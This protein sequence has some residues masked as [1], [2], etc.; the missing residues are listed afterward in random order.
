[1]Q[2]RFFKIIKFSVTF[3]AFG[4]FVFSFN[5]Q[6]AQAAITYVAA[7]AWTVGTTSLVPPLPAGMVA[8]D[9]ML[10]VMHTANHAVTTP[11]GWTEVT[12]SPISAGTANAAG[13]VRI[14]VYYRWWVSGDATPTVSVTS[15]T[16]TNGMIFGYRGVDMTTPFD[17]TPTS[18]IVAAASTT[19]TMAGIT[20]VT[21]NAWIVHSVGRDQ[22]L[23]N[24]AAVASPVNTNLTGMTERHD[25]VV[26][27]GV[28]GGIY[29]QD[30][31][32]GSAG[33]T[34][35]TTATQT[36]SIA[37]NLTVALRPS[38]DVA[39]TVTTPTSASITTT[40]A[41]L[42][43]N[44]T[45]LGIPASISAR[46]VVYGTSPSP[47][48]NATVASGTTTGVYTIGVSSLTCNTLYYY[49]GYATNTTGAAYSSDDSFT[50]SACTTAP[51][52]TTQA[53][54]SITTTTAT[55]NG[56]VTSDGGSAITERGIA[57]NTATAP[58]KANFFATTTGTTGAYT[59]SLTS[60]TSGTLYYVRAYAI[61]SVGTTY[62]NE[63][64]FT[65]L[66][67]PTVTTPTVTSITS[68]GATLGANVTSLGIPD[69]ISAR[70]TCW[71]T[72]PAPV[73][74][75]TAEGLTTTGV[76]T[77]ARTGMATGTLYYYRGYA[78]NTTGTAYS[79]DGTFT[80][81]NVPTITTQAVSSITTTTATG[82]GDVT[83]DGGSAITERGIA[84]NTATAPTKA[85]FFATTTGT[86]GAYTSS[87]TSLTSGTL[88]YVRAYA[89]NSV[90]TTYGNEVTFTT[91]I[92]PTVTTPT[93]TSITSSG[94][95][96]GANVTSLGIPAAI[97]ARGV[98]Y[99]TSPSP[100]GNATVA[101][102]TTTGVYTIGVSSLTCNTLYY[103]RGYATNTTGTAYSSD[104]SFTT[105]ACSTTT[106]SNGTDPGNSTIGPDVAATD[107]DKF[108]LTTSVSTDNITALTVTLAPANSF[109]NLSKVEIIHDGTLADECTDIDNP[110]SV[111]LN[112]TGCSLAADIDGEI[113]RIRITPKTH[114]NMP[115]VPGA[116]YTITATVTAITATNATA[117]TDSGSATITV[118]NA[119]P[120]GVTSSTATA[121]NTVVNLAWTNP[122]DSDFTTGGTVVVLRRATS[123]VENVPAEGTTYTIG[124][125]IGTATVACVVTGSPPTTSCSDTGLT[126]DTA[127]H[128]K[129][130][131]QDSRGNYD[132]GIVP[133]GS[134]ATPNTTTTLGNG[135]NPANVTIA[136]SAPVTDLNNFSVQTNSGTD[137]ITGLTVT[138]AAGT[139]ASLSLVEITTTGNTDVCTDVANPG[140]DAVAFT[141]CTI[142]GTTS[143]T[144]YKVRITPKTHINMPVPPGLN[145]SVTGTVTSA[146]S[147]NVKIYNDSGSAT[148]TVDNLSPAN[149]SGESATPDDV[150][151]SL[152][153]TNPTDGDFSN[154]V[155]LRDT[156][157]IGSGSTPSESSSPTLDSSC[158]GTNCLVRYINSGTSFIDT[159]LTNNTTYYYKIFSKDMNGNYSV[160]TQL[161]AT[162][163]LDPTTIITTG[164]D[165]ASS[166]V[167]ESSTNVYLDQFNFKTN[168]D[169]DSITALVV[170]TTG[171]SNIVSIKIMSNDLA[172]QYFTATTTPAGNNWSFAGGTSIPVSTTIASFRI[173]IDVKS[174]A[175]LGAGSFPVTGKVSSFTSTNPQS[176]LDS[177]GTTITIDLTP[178]AEV[179]AT[180]G[181]ALD[182]SVSLN[183]TNPVDSDFN[184]VVILRS[185]SAVTDSPVQGTSYSVGN[186]IGS[187]TV[188]CVTSS[189]S[190]TD[191]G[192]TNGTAYHY[193]IF[194]KDNF[195]NYSNGIVPTGSP[196]TPFAITTLANGTNPTSATIAPGAFVTSLDSFTLSVG[197]G[198]DSVTA[199]TVTLASS[200]YA[201]ISEIDIRSD[202]GLTLYFAAVSNPSSDIINFSGGTPIPVTTSTTQFKVRI[203]PKTHASMP[204]PPGVAY[205]V[206]GT[207]T[208]FS[209]TNTQGGTD[210]SSATITIDNASPENVVAS[211]GT[212]GGAQVTLNWTNPG[213][214]FSNA[215]ILRDTSSIGS[216]STPS[217]G[218]SP[219]VDS[220]CGGTACTVRY[221]SN[222]TSFID[223]SLINGTEYFYRIF[224]KDTAGNYS[225][226]GVVVN[227]TP[228]EPTPTPTTSGGGGGSYVAPTPL[229][230]PLVALLPAPTPEEISEE[231]P[232]IK[233]PLVPEEVRE[234]KPQVTTTPPTPPTPVFEKSAETSIPRIYLLAKNIKY[235]TQETV[236][237]MV[238][239]FNN[240]QEIFLSFGQRAGKELAQQTQ[241]VIKNLG[242]GINTAFRSTEQVINS[243]AIET[244][245]VIDGISRGV[246]V[247]FRSVNQ[248]ISFV[249]K[250]TKTLTD[251]TYKSADEFL[252]TITSV[253]RDNLLTV[254][255]ETLEAFNEISNVISNYKFTY[256]LKLKKPIA[257][258]EENFIFNSGELELIGTKDKP[259]QVVTGFKLK[260]KIKPTKP[261]KDITDT[262]KY[263][264]GADG[265]WS[266]DAQMPI[267]AGKF[268][269]RANINY[270]DGDSK[271]ISSLVLIDPEGY[272]YEQT[273]RGE[274]RVSNA[275]VSLWQKDSNKW[276]LWTAEKYGQSNPQITDKSGQ[277]SFLAP[278]GEY[279][280]EVSSE[281]YSSFRAQSFKLAEANPININIELKYKGLPF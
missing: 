251:T 43:A 196:F 193:K 104:D 142:S 172:T 25:Q 67:I 255:K 232:K 277:Y 162:P 208:A 48:G 205:A 230:Q 65:T 278:E 151:V 176:G 75:C 201:G 219:G 84:W 231:K 91:L 190:C 96:L 158:G 140:T 279:Y 152:A 49:R 15:G 259:V 281:N 187:A 134:P 122:A 243:I 70:G 213:S 133:T 4:F 31:I 2:K 28:G 192:L 44:V 206:T 106:L 227:A 53:V 22:D 76:F 165:P 86:T 81:L 272:V 30:G 35:D 132:A 100:T 238:N 171:T 161:S 21:A 118:D 147:T 248:S 280:I 71:G 228:T 77:H 112:F 10:L 199:L 7:G 200:T 253:D 235:S 38:P 270:E 170:T 143:L 214:D 166:S 19:L 189:T 217:E 12:G 23:N 113:F 222:G 17:A 247:A 198:S 226:T 83:S 18:N 263:T 119:S 95:T 129:I 40:T 275:T 101:S 264:E 92:I 186:T 11:T 268:A 236:K 61:N 93:V 123:A 33:A 188:A 109:N 182:A 121:G 73:T 254:K 20:T 183:W 177:V 51:T 110:S 269:L 131:T 242:K 85:N 160:G 6:Q 157:T 125:T 174:R 42:G 63:V 94:A 144:E 52:V 146:T 55:G 163:S 27:T 107:I 9:L 89:I 13:G 127:Y 59:S 164:T 249:T 37:V 149:V 169:A 39:P 139:A 179:S 246:S 1:M 209:S 195:S 41:T 184:A 185:L 117:G 124:N 265:V 34:G 239:S 103:Y 218:S 138:F 210:S 116:S 46:G 50:T 215:V 256:S 79:A 98:V 97:S 257:I 207:V 99:G 88:Y 36:S 244:E 212:A 181:T 216:A 80:T 233:P 194:A 64:T 266:A 241:T 90:G 126:N 159:G 141:G 220:L 69:T 204:V 258:A 45:S 271:E 128:Y 115:A 225:A 5:I 66:I 72:S 58:T 102:G 24:A 276:V 237:T 250:G 150:Q 68:S 240:F 108:T 168:I 197:S 180:S 211:S 82:N 136:P 16:V 274:L 105:S 14:T 262:F 145:Y 156:A 114:A 153:W 130:F 32:M 54:S 8:G 111:T 267:I 155:I 62:G 245:K 260:I 273:S 154:V 57:W 261:A 178:P 191:T 47:T 3:F 229:P 60:L 137:A 26:N 224:T 175:S 148:I 167:A 74:N 173:I 223:T 203:T 135:T 87:L 120:A 56:D 234:E 252:N 78:I 202:D 221:I 29:V